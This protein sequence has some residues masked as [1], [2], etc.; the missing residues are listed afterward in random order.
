[1]KK[2]ILLLALL[3]G[4]CDRWSDPKATATG[5]QITTGG[6]SDSTIQEIE[7]DGCQYL[8]IMV[9]GCGY[10][11]THKGNCKRCLERAQPIQAERK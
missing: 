1:M 2:L 6:G 5:N 4:G 3:A 8:I 11:I 9:S 7:Y 10:S